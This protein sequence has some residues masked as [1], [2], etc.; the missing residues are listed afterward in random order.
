MTANEPLVTEGEAASL[1]CGSASRLYV[2]GGAEDVDPFT[3][4]S[5][6]QCVTAGRIWPTSSRARAA[7][8]PGCVPGNWPHDLPRERNGLIV[9]LDGR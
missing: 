6:A 4:R 7:W 3:A 9:V 2:A 8:K 5:G 1:Y